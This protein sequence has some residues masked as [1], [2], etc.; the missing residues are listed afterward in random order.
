MQKFKL[1][2]IN[3]FKYIKVDQL[4]SWGGVGRF[5][6]KLMKKINL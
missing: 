4:K 2:N 6:F 5:F 3:R 1:G